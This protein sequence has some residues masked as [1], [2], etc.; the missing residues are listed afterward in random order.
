MMES[1]EHNAHVSQA[2]QTGQM[3]TWE[4]HLLS[5][6]VI[7]SGSTD[8][9]FGIPENHP[10]KTLELYLSRVHPDDLQI[11]EN[12]IR[13]S[14]S[15]GVEHFVEYRVVTPRGHL[16]WIASRGNAILD[17]DNRIIKIAGALVDIT[18]RKSAEEAL[19]ISEERFRLALKGAP[20][21]VFNQDLNLR[22]TWIYNS[23]VGVPSEEL[24]G[25]VE[26][27]I[28]ERPQ[29][30][31]TLTLLKQRVIATGRSVQ[32]DVAVWRGGEERY[33]SMAIEPLRDPKGKIVGITGVA[34]D[35]T[36]LKRIEATLREREHFINRVTEATPE[37]I[38]VYNIIENRNTYVNRQAA[39]QLGYSEAEIQAMG[40]NLLPTILHPDEMARV[41]EYNRQWI[42]VPEG[43]T[44]DRE[45]RLRNANGEWCWYLS[46][47]A[48]F[49]RTENGEVKE[50]IGTA[51]DITRRKRAEERTHLLQELTAE[52]S[53]SL[54]VEQ[55][56]DAILN[57]GIKAMGGIRGSLYQ[58]SEKGDSLELLLCKGT[59]PEEAKNHH[60]LSL[61]LP[62]PVVDTM[63]TQQITWLEN[64]EMIR[65]QYPKMAEFLTRN[66]TQAVICIPMTNSS[67]V[68]GVLH[69]A[70][71]I[72]R[73]INSEDQDLLTALAQHCAQALER[74]RLQQQAERSAAFEERQRLAREL[75]DAVSQTLFSATTIA[76]ALPIIW[77]RNTERG[78][79]QLEQLVRLNRAALAEMRT[80]LLEL[81]PEAI[82]RTS[83]PG[84]LQQLMEAA[85]GRKQI[86][87]ALN[88]EG[89]ILPLPPDVHVALYRIA[90]ESLNNSLKHSQATHIQI[91]FQRHP[92]GAI[93]LMQDNGSG[94]DT[95]AI[96]SGLGLNTMRER[97]D[98]IGASYRISSRAGY[99]T[100]VEV[101]WIDRTY[102]PTDEAYAAAS[103]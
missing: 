53:R 83:L 25:K 74:V 69:L 73:K 41:G 18:A 95:R 16:R 12:A 71:G 14:A 58:L 52:L 26:S 19:R 93:L 1:Q 34:T 66:N 17:S 40:G 28:W 20:I 75:H 48:I 56:S 42:D 4:L 85:K 102:A 27:D 13:Q 5:G 49:S 57:V 98:A 79:V 84:L 72:S 59:T 45:Y 47:E 81:R 24:I 92:D 39:V 65:E 101:V 35:I 99:G 30:A 97:A 38:Y 15:G 9:L 80:L 29:D 21:V 43:E 61:S 33:Y 63:R 82:V 11:T 87:I 89:E 51:Q 67:G 46:R 100:E 94:F 8:M 37:I 22:H 91:S 96:S 50:V 36:H 86:N 2:L 31:Q 3:G 23:Q 6:K 32:Q 88:E 77:E 60:Q 44:I 7:T 90:Q 55:I 78:S 64:V 68:L 62:L 70:L 103:R 76:E 10:D 54:T